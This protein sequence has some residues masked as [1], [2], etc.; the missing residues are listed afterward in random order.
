MAQDA[1]DTLQHSL[2]G[3][4]L[5]AG[6][7]DYDAVRQVWN[8][9]IDKRPALIARCHG[10]ADVIAAVNFARAHNLLVAV[11]GGGHNVAGLAVCEGGLMIDLSPMRGVWVDPVARTARVQGGAVWRDVDYE[12]QAFGLAVPGGV[13]STTG[14]AG[15]TLGGGY[16]WLRSKYGLTCDCLRSVDI[17]TADGQLLTASPE[18]HADLFW[19]IQGGGGN[20]G[21]VTSFEFQLYPAGPQVVLCA[22]IYPAADAPRIYRVWRDFMATAPDEFSCDA[23][24]WTLPAHPNFSPE[25]WGKDI[26]LI[27]GVYCGALE[28][29]EAL[30]EPLRRLGEPLLDLSG[31]WPYLQVQ[32]A[33]APFFPKGEFAHYWKSLYLDRLDDSAIDLIFA[34]YQ[35]RPSARTLIPIRHLGG[36]I[37]RV[38]SVATAFG[39]RSAPF[40]VSIDSTWQEP[41]DA[42]VNIAW[43]RAFWS[44]LQPYSS[45]KTYFNFPGL[46]EEGDALVRTTFGANHERLVALKNKYDPTN[47]FRLNQNIKP[48]PRTERGL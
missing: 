2:R 19:G 41:E 14:V 8:G 42:A 32:Q 27:A 7:A 28:A 43:T 11:R 30:I 35:T 13:V 10:A 4:L 17:V 9:M 16:G 12:T 23:G 47:L 21:I 18:R 44:A 3:E 33:F 37:R 1:V 46:L 38:A 25:V 5:G 24:L 45:G 36:A 26:I 48:T 34:Q 6:D 20:F 22:P 15:Y 39:D 31:R 40:L 29:G